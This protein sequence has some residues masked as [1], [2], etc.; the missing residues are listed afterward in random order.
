MNVFQYTNQGCRKINQDY[1]LCKKLNDDKSVFVVA[2]GMGGYSFG[3]I[4]SLVVANSII[5][6]AS[7]HY[8]DATDK[9][10]TDALLFANDSLMIKR[11]GMGC[12]RMGAVVVVAYID[13]NKVT[14]AWLG[15]SRGYVIR[16]GKEL[17]HTEDHSMLNEIRQQR[18][19]TMSDIELYSSMVTRSI[20]GT[21]STDDIST[22]SIEL[23]D[24]D[25]VLLCSDGL[26]KESN[27]LL[28]PQD[29]KELTQYLDKLKDKM[30]D[31]YSLVRV[32]V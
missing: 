1:C 8:L 20:M 7:E 19:V 28:L 6:Y 23:Q 14:F 26:Y 11:L 17:Y 4:A 22:S 27:V 5:E 10:L 16:N 13:A 30:S 12:Q 2:D 25:Q 3:E 18:L 9:M 32:T 21:D 15:D 31:N 24:L 29:E